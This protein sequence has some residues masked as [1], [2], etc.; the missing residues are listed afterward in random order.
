MTYMSVKERLEK[1]KK[2]GDLEFVAMLELA[3]ENGVI[4]LEDR[5]DVC[6]ENVLNWWE[7]FKERLKKEG[8]E[9]RFFYGEKEYVIAK[10]VKC[11]NCGSKKIDQAHYDHA[12][13][14]EHYHCENCGIWFD[15]KGRIEVSLRWLRENTSKIAERFREAVS[16]TPPRECVL[17]NMFFE[18]F[19]SIDESEIEHFQQIADAFG[20]PVNIVSKG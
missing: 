9:I 2:D 13:E 20:I 6:E 17:C 14:M 4:S 7:S 15:E 10:I 11:P 8:K 18:D 19:E 1:A 16:L 5:W 3:V 12:D